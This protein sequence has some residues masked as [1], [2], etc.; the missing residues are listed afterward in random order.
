MSGAGGWLTPLPLA[1]RA[2]IARRWPSVSV[3]QI[4]SEFG[5]YLNERDGRAPPAN[6][7]RKALADLRAKLRSAREAADRVRQLYP[8]MAY[9]RAFLSHQGR[10][11]VWKQMVEASPFIEAVLLQV[12]ARLRRAPRQNPH[13]T[14]ARRLASILAD[15]GEVVDARPNGALCGILGVILEAAGEQPSSLPAIARIAI[16]RRAAEKTRSV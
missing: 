5:Y 7:Q 3:S 13:S 2:E 4:E 14:L 6:E 15:A 9:I 16:P 8:S 10:P 12:E 1:S 11:D